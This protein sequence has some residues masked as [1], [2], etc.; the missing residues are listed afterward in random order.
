[1]WKDVRTVASNANRRKKHYPLPK[2]ASAQCLV[3][4]VIFKRRLD[5]AQDR[6]YDESSEDRNCFRELSNRLR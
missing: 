6:N 5:M 1:M 2:Y 3:S 4:M